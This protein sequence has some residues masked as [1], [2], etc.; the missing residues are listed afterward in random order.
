MNKSER[1]FRRYIFS[2]VGIIILFL[3]VN[4]LLVASFFAVGYLGN[5][6]NS[7]FPIEDFS[8]HVTEANGQFNADTRAEEMLN[9]TGAWAMIL[10]ENGSAIWEMNMPEELPRHYSTTDVAMFS[11]WY[12]N[13]YPVNIWNRQGNL[14]VVGFPQ[15]DI[16]NYYISIKTQYVRPIAFGFL[17]AVCINVL[18][19]LYLFVRNAHRVEKAME[20]ILNG[21][22][23][24]SAGRPI[25]L[26]E[27]G[28]LAEINAGLNR[29]GDYLL[30]KDN[31]RAEWIRGISHDIRTPLSM[32]LGYASEIE[33]TSSLPETARKQAEIIRRHS[34]KLKNLVAD[35]NLTTK[36]EYSM[37]PMQEQTLDPVDLARQAVSEV[38][39]DG[40]SDKYEL[41]LSEDNPGKAIN[42]TGDPSLLNRM[43]C[44]LIR[45]CIVHNPNGCRI[46]VSV[47]SCDTTC[48]F[49]V[50]D[51]GCGMSEPQRNILNSDKDI[52]STQKPTGEIEHGLG[53]KIVRQIVK[54]HQGKIQFSDTIPHGLNVTIHLPIQ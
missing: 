25:R 31:T 18:L 46:Q 43:L 27:T 6:K 2:I 24:L 45:N 21:I 1:F 16:T 5:V 35:L 13:N 53:L 8:E 44:N 33:E 20:P 39:N 11:R 30:K 23:H 48:A 52:S 26:K 10:N 40:L 28:E 51:N 42:I 3:F 50:T 37:Q 54:V 12:L 32:I 49:S 34:E 36:L 14:L 22:R 41:V 47:G 38:L 17:A 29:A 15:E 4:I 9:N 19:M 7:N